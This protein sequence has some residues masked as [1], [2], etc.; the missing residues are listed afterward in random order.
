[1]EGRGKWR[2][3]LG[4][5][6]WVNICYGWVG[7][8]GGIFWVG[9]EGG[10]EWGWVVVSGVVTQFSITQNYIQFATSIIDPRNIIKVLPSAKKNSQAICQIFNGENKF[11]RKSSPRK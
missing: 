11:M 8:D 5:L 9:G 6:G 1:M 10:G 3:I 4:R 2:Y 7:V